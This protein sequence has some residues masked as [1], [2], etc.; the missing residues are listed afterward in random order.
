M[1]NYF[2]CRVQ[3]GSISCWGPRDRQKDAEMGTECP[4]ARA[5]RQEL[6]RSLGLR[7]K[8]FLAPLVIVTTPLH[9]VRAREGR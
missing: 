7:I 3:L 1:T 9:P 4:L 2:S 5:L 6:P 8:T